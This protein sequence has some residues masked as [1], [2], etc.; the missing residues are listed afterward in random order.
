MQ[1]QTATKKLA[2]LK[3]AARKKEKDNY[4]TSNLKLQK[5]KGLK[6][7]ITNYKVLLET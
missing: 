3:N 4:L 1:E 6:L 5:T 2:E 7:Q